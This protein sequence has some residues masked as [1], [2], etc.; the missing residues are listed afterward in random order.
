MLELK[1]TL[2]SLIRPYS[3]A[4]IGKT[5]KHPS[6]RA[7]L[8][9]FSEKEYNKFVTLN[10]VRDWSQISWKDVGRPYEVKS[11]AKDRTDWEEK[12]KMEMDPHTSWTFF[13]KAFHEWFMKD[14]PEETDT[15]KKEFINS[16]RTFNTGEVK[17][18]L[19]SIVQLQLWNYVHR[20]QDGVWDPRGKRALFEGLDVQKP[21]ILFLGAAEGYEAMQLGAMYPGAEIVMV[22]YDEYCRTNRFPDFPEHYPFLGENP[23]TGQHKVFYKNDFQIEYI[24]D[25]IRNLDFGREFDIVLSVGL[26]EHFPDEYKHEV[27]DWHRRFLKKGGYAVMTTPRKQIRSKIYYRIMADVMNHTYRELMTVKQMGLYMYES[28]FDILKH[29]YIKVHNGLVCRPR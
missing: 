11:Y 27:A 3:E 29:G 2:P 8:R 17:Q 16:L 14:V 13:N 28:G 25:D 9:K 21:R 22:D 6:Y 19:G 15:A 5:V 18:A 24:V 23:S 1:T 20:I 26:L 4:D 7:D 10:T 12:H